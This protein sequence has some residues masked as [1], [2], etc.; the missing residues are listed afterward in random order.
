[1]ILNQLNILIIFGAIMKSMFILI[2]IFLLTNSLLSQYRNPESAIWDYANHR[3]YITNVGSGTITMRNWG[4]STTASWA[5]G[6]IQPKAMLIIDSTL[7]VVDYTTMKTYNTNTGQ[8]LNNETVPGATFMND[9]C[10]DKEGNFYITETY[11]NSIIKWTAKTKK[12][13]KLPLKGSIVMPNGIMYDDDRLIVVS[14][15][16]NSPI[17]AISLS[18]FTVST[19]KETQI[20]FMDGIAKDGKG[21]VFISAWIDQN[22]GSGK[23]YRIKED[24]SG[25]LEVVV[26]NLDGPADIY[27]N[28]FNDTLVIPNMNSNNVRFIGFIDPPPPPTLLEPADGSVSK[29]QN[30]MKWKRPRAATSYQL[31][32]G[33]APDMSDAVLTRVFTDTTY[34][35]FIDDNDI[36]KTIYWRVR[37]INSEGIGEWSDIWSLIPPSA[38]K[39]VLSYPPNETI[40]L[41]PDFE[42]IWRPQ[43]QTFILMIDTKEDFTSDELII[44]ETEQNQTQVSGLK[45]N[46]RYYW[47]VIGQKCDTREESA[48]WWFELK[49]VSLPS[50]AQL[51]KPQ[52]LSVDMPLESIEFEWETSSHTDNYLFQLSA[53]NGFSNIIEFM[54]IAHTNDNNVTY[55][56]K[57]TL[58]CNRTYY[59][60]VISSNEFGTTDS[61]V[62]SFET[63]PCT[64]VENKDFTIRT[65]I[66]PNP[67]IDYIEI[68]IPHLEKGLGGVVPVV[69]VYDVLG[70]EQPVSYSATPLS[71]GKL[72]LNVSHLPM[73]VY[74]VRVGG[75]VQKFVKM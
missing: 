48:V 55:T 69:R 13:S 11:D 47:K 61:K 14:Y 63:E 66:I 43:D 2:V 56:L 68:T 40:G 17:Q 65:M 58:E 29:I 60:K 50:A 19:L 75:I 4:G 23:V 72:R 25:E 7:Y 71:D 32:Y 15:R 21:N 28:Q 70:M 10:M 12:Y 5:S 20:H 34:N 16:Q 9:I 36:C 64:G 38:S 31:E 45:P 35:L 30:M 52:D 22:P 8:F 33:F 6:L 39:P 27:Y 24:F 42:F 59:W 44:K 74:F 54:S 57:N 67:A 62:F 18:D 37:G 3:Y 49:D 73:G 26:S 46:V 41:I 53:H 1:M 51:I